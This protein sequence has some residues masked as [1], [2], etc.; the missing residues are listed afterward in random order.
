[1]KL[2]STV[3]FEEGTCSRPGGSNSEA[4]IYRK[5]R[6]REEEMLFHTWNS[7]CESQVAWGSWPFLGTTAPV[8]RRG[9]CRGWPRQTSEGPVKCVKE[10]YLT[11]NGKPLKSLQ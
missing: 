9:G 2:G 8:V 5:D 10:T 3:T 1:M 4:E 6:Q 7:I 11:S